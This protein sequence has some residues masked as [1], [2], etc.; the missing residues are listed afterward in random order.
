MTDP[1][2]DKRTAA[3]L[4]ASVDAAIRFCAGVRGSELSALTELAY[5]L[6][7]RTAEVEAAVKGLR[8]ARQHLVDQEYHSALV[9]VDEALA[10]LTPKEDDHAE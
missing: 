5:R 8:W 10:A 4:V 7:K 3:E 2:R 6:A 1:T 9:T